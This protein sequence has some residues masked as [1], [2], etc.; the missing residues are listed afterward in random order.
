MQT[1]DFDFELPPELI[2]TQASAQRSQ[3]RL[4][5]VSQNQQQLKDFKFCDIPRLLRQGDLL[6]FNNTK[7]IPARLFG[8]KDS[9]GEVEVLIERV[10]NQHEALAHVRSNRSPKPGRLLLLENKQLQ[11]EVLG[12]Q[13]EF[14][15]LRFAG[16]ASLLELLDSY[17]RIPL[18]PYIEREAEQVDRERYQTIYAKHPGAVAAPTAGLHFDHALLDQLK[19]LG[20]NTCEVTLHV[21]AGT[22]QPV[23][24]DN[25]FEHQM[26]SERFVLNH[27]AVEAIKQTQEQGG[28]VIAVGTTSVRVLETVAARGE[29][30]ACEGETDIFIYPGFEFKVIDALITNFHLPQ[31][32]L[33]MLVSALAGRE[34][35]LNAYQHAIEQ[36]YRFYSYGDAMIIL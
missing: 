35:I 31:S 16:E 22:F 28:R 27:A 32:T 7:V 36:R 30:E 17:G 34:T 3:S 9:G 11:A 25:I 21:G 20:V 10:L 24:V 8:E 26:H 4:L 19:Q 23:R 14:F 13:G 1:R 2:A 5:C 18:P 6:V 29:F 15:H 12:R 33:L